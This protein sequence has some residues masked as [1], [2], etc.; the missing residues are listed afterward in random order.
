[1]KSRIVI[2]IETE[3]NPIYPIK[4]DDT[5][6]EENPVTEDVEKELHQMIDKYIRDYIEEQLE[7]EIMDNISEV[8]YSIE[9]FDSFSDYGKF[10]F[11]VTSGED[12]K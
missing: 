5:L 6:D 12:A 7:E 3:L 4:D 1:M 11:K 2:E 8:E 10:H 9:D